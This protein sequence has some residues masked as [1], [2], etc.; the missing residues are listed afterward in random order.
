MTTLYEHVP[1]PHVKRRA[2]PVHR[3]DVHPVGINGKIAVLLTNGVGTMICA[4]AF[5]V[6]AILGFPGVSV[7]LN[8]ISYSPDGVTGQQYVQGVSQTCI[9]LVMLSIIMVGQKILGAAADKRS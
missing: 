4:Y 9:Q 5:M 3:E 6:L 7:S 2:A 8:K 1:H